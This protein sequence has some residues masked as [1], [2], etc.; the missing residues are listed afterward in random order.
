MHI[1]FQIPNIRDQSLNAKH[2]L[3]LTA[4]S[5][6]KGRMAEWAEANPNCPYNIAIVEE[7]IQVKFDNPAHTTLWSLTW[8]QYR[9]NYHATSWKRITIVE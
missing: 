2:N 7:A 9:G 5:I 6:V 4:S 3:Y 1:E 8:D